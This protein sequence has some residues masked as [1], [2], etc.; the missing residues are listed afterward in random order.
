MVTVA[1][2]GLEIARMTSASRVLETS[3][4]PNY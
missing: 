2:G 1:F 4:P 3:H